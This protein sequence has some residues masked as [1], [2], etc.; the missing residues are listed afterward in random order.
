MLTFKLH[1]TPTRYLMSEKPPEVQ[2]DTPGD[3]NLGHVISSVLVT[4]S[5]VVGGLARG[6]H[7]RDGLREV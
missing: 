4:L 1:V 3:V 7:A 2:G 5:R 6:W